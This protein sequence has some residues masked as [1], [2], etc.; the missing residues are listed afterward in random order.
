MHLVYTVFTLIPLRMLLCLALASEISAEPFQYD[1]ARKEQMSVPLSSAGEKSVRNLFSEENF[2]NNSGIRTVTSNIVTTSNQG[3][4]LVIGEVYTTQQRVHVL[5]ND[6]EILM[7]F[8][9]DN[10]ILEG[11]KC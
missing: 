1:A 11:H 10:R 9:G 6:N 4:N 2:R 5:Q 7:A 3:R 8:L